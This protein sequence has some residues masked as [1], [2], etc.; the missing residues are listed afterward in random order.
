MGIAIVACAL[1]AG[2]MHPPKYDPPKTPTPP[3]YKEAGADVLQPAQPSD[4]K[5]RAAWWETFNDP[6]LNEL[7][8]R[9]MAGN[10]SLAQAVARYVQA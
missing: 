10:P 4:Q 1:A 5:P 8:T 3:N 9:V 6:K 2:C 7:E